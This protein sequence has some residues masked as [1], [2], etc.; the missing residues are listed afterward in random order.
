MF[1]GNEFRGYKASTNNFCKECYVK[2]Y[3]ELRKSIKKEKV[4]VLCKN[5]FLANSNN[6]FSLC[7]KCTVTN[8]NRKYYIEITKPGR[9]LARQIKKG[10][11]L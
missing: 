3:N 2:K 9:E 6:Q 11:C 5:V 10:N 1:C 4:C 8:M 7:P